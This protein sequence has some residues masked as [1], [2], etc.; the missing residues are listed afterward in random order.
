MR[1]EMEALNQQVLQHPFRLLPCRSFWDIR[2]D[3]VL[4]RDDPS[5]TSE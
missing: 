5:P 3:V 1:N 4:L 2:S